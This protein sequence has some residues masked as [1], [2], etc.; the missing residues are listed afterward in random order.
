MTSLRRLKALLSVVLLFGF[1]VFINDETDRITGPI[2]TAL[3]IGV[4]ESATGTVISGI[5]IVVP[6]LLFSYLILPDKLLGY[7]YIKTPNKEDIKQIGVGLAYIFTVYFALGVVL[8]AL[9]LEPAS[10]EVVADFEENP[11][12]LPIMITTTFLIVAPVEELIFRGVMQRYLQDYYHPVVSIGI[13]SVLFAGAHVAV[14]DGGIS[15][16]LS[17][18]LLVGTIGGIFG[19]MYYK[20][21][22]LIVPMLLHAIYNTTLLTFLFIELTM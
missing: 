8:I 15:G 18:I 5:L 22:N 6:T 14:L 19:Y 12:L 16:I 20:T 7:A 4:L 13:S 9:G 17:Y 2:N 3:E 21:R 11:S 10:N 1:I